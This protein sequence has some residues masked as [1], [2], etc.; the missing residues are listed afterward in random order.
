MNRLLLVCISLLLAFAV[1]LTA[2]IVAYRWSSAYAYGDLTF[3]N[4]SLVD[5]RLTF[6]VRSN[7]EGEYVYKLIADSDGNGQITLTVRGGKQSALAQSPGLDDAY[8]HIDLPEGTR[9][10]VCGKSTVYTVS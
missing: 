1:A 8:F 7:V 10:L 2:G 5:G 3:D 4:F 9:K 6:R